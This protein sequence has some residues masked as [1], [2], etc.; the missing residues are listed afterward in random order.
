MASD[1]PPEWISI[2]LA[3]PE[4]ARIRTLMDQTEGAAFTD[5]ALAFGVGRAR[6]RTVFVCRGSVMDAGA[7]N[8][9]VGTVTVLSGEAGSFAAAMAEWRSGETEP[10]PHDPV[11]RLGVG[12]AIGGHFEIAARAWVEGV[13]RDVDHVFLEGMPGVLSWS[14]GRPPVAYDLPPERV[15][16][17]TSSFGIEAWQRLRRSTA[18]VIGAGGTGSITIPML[19]RAGVGRIV[20]VDSDHI[21]PSNLERTHASFPRHVEARTLKA[22]LAR[23]HV[24]A[25]DPDIEVIAYEGR[26]P[27]ADIVAEVLRADV[28]VGCTDQHT[29]RLAVAD[30][31]RR[32]LVPAIDCGGLIEGADGRVTGQIIQLVVF[33]PDD[34]CPVCRG[35]ID[36]VRVAQELMSDEERRAIR[37]R[38]DEGAVP[39]EAHEIPQIDTVGYITTVSGTLA[40]GYAIGWLTGRFD[41]PFE[42]M[43]MNLI[44]DCLDVTNRPQKHDPDCKC[45]QSRG[46]GDLGGELAPFAVP[47]HWKPARRIV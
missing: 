7:D 23:D 18:V 16:R 27:Q 19:A 11:L 31:A 15:A 47:N 30:M 36:P 22:E 41:P 8:R 28:L 37:G 9:I 33:R 5:L 44:A 20:I 2:R 38:A 43:Q 4:V 21:T 14:G 13:W 1:M 25:I 40:A 3:R 10:R 26:L 24:R 32:Y 17:F 46:L 12:P 34:P 42:R 35:M 29:S 6:G 39:R 45:R